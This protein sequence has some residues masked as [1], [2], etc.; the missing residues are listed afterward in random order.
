MSC[1][2]VSCHGHV[3]VCLLCVR[4]HNEVYTFR[5]ASAIVHNLILGKLWIE[6]VG[7][8]E[9]VNPITKHRIIVQLKPAGRHNKDLYSV[10]AAVL[11][12]VYATNINTQV[13]IFTYSTRTQL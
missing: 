3:L 11:D 5:T 12:P 13:L 10:E 8:Q 2:V 4:R 6:N 9:A 7:V 1:R